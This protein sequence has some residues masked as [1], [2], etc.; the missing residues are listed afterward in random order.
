MRVKRLYRVTALYRGAHT[1]R[2]D[3]QTR[4]AAEH[5]AE[6]LRTPAPD[7]MGYPAVA[8]AVTITVSDPITWPTS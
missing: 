2:R 7:G 6:V 5:H 3:Y 1:T 4:A 8:S